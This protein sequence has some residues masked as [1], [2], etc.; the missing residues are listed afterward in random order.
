MA[1]LYMIVAMLFGFALSVQAQE[2]KVIEVE[3]QKD[4]DQIHLHLNSSSVGYWKISSEDATKSLD[5]MGQEQNILPSLAKN[6][7]NG[8][9][10]LNLDV[11]EK[12][13][14]WDK[15]KQ[16][17]KK[18]KRN[19]WKLRLG[20]NKP[21]KMDL[22]YSYGETELNLSEIPCENLKLNSGNA[23]ILIAYDSGHV[24]K[25]YMDSFLVDIS[26]GDLVMKN[27]HHSRAAY[28]QTD[29]AFGNMELFFDETEFDEALEIH[30]SVGAGNLTINLPTNVPIAIKVRNSPLSKFSAPLHFEKLEDGTIVNALYDT[31]AENILTFDL[32]VSVGKIII[33]QN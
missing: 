22:H 12:K 15:F 4:V 1:R 31:D 30:A 18:N 20:K 33:N 21:I 17:F 14:S 28:F 25:V 26:M 6:N 5:L 2:K 10:N 13:I 7:K 11:K 9:L 24:N 19:S 32:D 8:E 29:V 23:D 16:L 3:D 27:I